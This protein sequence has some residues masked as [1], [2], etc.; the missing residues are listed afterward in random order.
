MPAMALKPMAGP[1]EKP[2][3][4][5]PMIEPMIEK[6]RGERRH[7]VNIER[8]E[9]AHRLRRQGDQQEETAS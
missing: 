5:P 3:N 4:N 7:A 6:R 8:V 1:N 2:R 9:H